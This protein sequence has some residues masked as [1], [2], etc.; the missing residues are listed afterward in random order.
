MRFRG[1]GCSGF[2]VPLCPPDRPPQARGARSAAAAAALTAEKAH[3]PLER[4]ARGARLTRGLAE[5]VGDVRVTY[6][7]AED[8]AIRA[9]VWEIEDGRPASARGVRH[10]GEEKGRRRGRLVAPRT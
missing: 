5:P 6:T 9:W 7:P 1:T 4:D 2:R 10:G 3:E 8:E